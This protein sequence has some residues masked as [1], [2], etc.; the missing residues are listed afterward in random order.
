VEVLLLSILVVAF[1]DVVCLRMDLST[2]R[3][4]VYKS[5]L[6]SFFLLLH[7]GAKRSR[8]REEYRVL[9]V[10]LLYGTCTQT[11]IENFPERQNTRHSQTLVR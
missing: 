2:S 5:K 11:I 4:V 3:G 7:G 9:P 1:L 8:L 6:I 10:P